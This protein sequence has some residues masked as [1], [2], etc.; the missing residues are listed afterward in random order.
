MAARA[1]AV[2]ETLRH[3]G[4]APSRRVGIRRPMRVN[5]LEADPE[6]GSYLPPDSSRS[7]QGSLLADVL[8]LSAGPWL[9]PE[10]APEPGRL[11]YL[12]LSGMLVRRVTVDRSRSGELLAAGALIRP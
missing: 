4:E 2:R 10:A 6:L 3:I 1:I 12:I 7:L 9:P 8:E 5:L 11:G